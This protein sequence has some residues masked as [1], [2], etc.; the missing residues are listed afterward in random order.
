MFYA[1]GLELFSEAYANLDA[2]D[3]SNPVLPP[4]LEKA[5][6]ASGPKKPKPPRPAKPAEG[7]TQAAAAAAG[8]S[9]GGKHHLHHSSRE[10]SWCYS[11]PSPAL[12]SLSLSLCLS[13][14]LSTNVNT[15]HGDI[16]TTSCNTVLFMQFSMLTNTSHQHTAHDRWRWRTS[17]RGKG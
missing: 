8:P 7:A 2:I 16:I 15:R 12:L 6:A 11:Y 14:S 13:I 4:V 5:R 3:T 9:S 17:Q 10:K 1:R